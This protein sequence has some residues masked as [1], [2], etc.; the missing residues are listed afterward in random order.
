MKRKKYLITGCAGFIGSNL[1]KVLYKNYDLILVDD[2]S[3]G[4]VQNLPKAVRGKLI[5]KKIQNIKSFKTKKIDGIFH[6]AAQASV[7]LSLKNFYKSSSNNLTSSIKVFEISKKYS[8]PV[9][10]ASS[11]AIYGNLPLGDDTINKFLITSPYA[12]D[13]LSIEDY[14]KLSFKIFKVPSIGFRFF[15]VYGPGQ[16]S[17]SP[18]SSVIPIFINRMLKKLPVTINGGFQTRDFIYIEDVIYVMIKS[19]NKLKQKKIFKIY[20]LG[21]GRSVT[22]DKLFNIIKK[23]L[24][25]KIKVI[26]KKLEKFDPKKSSGNFNKVNK[27]LNLNKNN[28]TKLEVGLSKTIHYMKNNR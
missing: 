8:A 9:V 13:K 5:K 6:L 18:Y 16:S 24:G 26:Y 25:V 23:N 19:M 15:N 10:Y 11:S 28:F 27:F 21:T 7:P 2:L 17:V 22:I 4:K 14:A 3:E 12:Q 20:N 1:V